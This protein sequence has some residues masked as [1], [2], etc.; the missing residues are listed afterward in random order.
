MGTKSDHLIQ[1]VVR[2]LASTCSRLAIIATLVL[3]LLIIF[4]L[5]HSTFVPMPTWT[6]LRSW[7][8]MTSSVACV[9]LPGSSRLRQ[10]HVASGGARRRRSGSRATTDKYL[11]EFATFFSAFLPLHTHT[12]TTSQCALFSSLLFAEAIKKGHQPK[13]NGQA[14]A[15]KDTHTT[16]LLWLPSNFSS[17][18]KERGAC[19]NTPFFYASARG[20]QYNDGD[21]PSPGPCPVSARLSETGFWWQRGSLARK[22][23]NP[24]NLVSRLMLL[25][26]NGLFSWRF[27]CGFLLLFLNVSLN[28]EIPKC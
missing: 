25:L 27:F 4:L 6:P 7:N 17:S 22:I 15:D 14:A 24:K 21:A 16:D 9:F 12:H 10:F 20:C 2:W 5:A 3:V 8:I 11:C 23:S 18:A 1:R 28:C 19:E 26:P 13:S